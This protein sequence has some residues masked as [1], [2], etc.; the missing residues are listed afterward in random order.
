MRNLLSV[1][2]KTRLDN[3]FEAI[4]DQD[5]D[6]ISSYLG[7]LTNLTGI[8]DDGNTFMHLVCSDIAEI[9]ELDQKHP[10]LK[11][12][13]QLTKILE[14]DQASAEFLNNNKE[15]PLL[16]MLEAIHY[17][18][19]NKPY[20]DTLLSYTNTID[21]P[22]T[23]SNQTLLSQA[24][25]YDQSYI[26]P[27]LEHDASPLRPVG[28]DEFACSNFLRKFSGS[29]KDMAFLKSLLKEQALS[30]EFLNHVIKKSLFNQKLHAELE[31]LSQSDPD[32]FK[33]LLN[34][35]NKQDPKTLKSL[36]Q[37]LTKTI[38]AKLPSLC[39]ILVDQKFPP[40]R[41]LLETLSIARRSNMPKAEFYDQIYTLAA[42]TGV[43]NQE[44]AITLNEY[45]YLKLMAKHGNGPDHLYWSEG[46]QTTLLHQLCHKWR[47][48]DKET[49]LVILDIIEQ[50]NSIL[51]NQKD[52]NGNRIADVILASEDPD[53]IQAAGVLEILIGKGQE[54]ELF[55]Y[56]T[57]EELA[58][59]RFRHKKNPEMMDRIHRQD[60][61][62]SDREVIRRLIDIASS[63]GNVSFL[64]DVEGNQHFVP[65]L[66]EHERAMRLLKS[67]VPELIE[68]HAKKMTHTLYKNPNA[69]VPMKQEEVR[70]T[71]ASWREKKELSKS[72]YVGSPEEL[73]RYLEAQKKPASRTTTPQILYLEDQGHAIT[74]V[75]YPNQKQPDQPTFFFIDSFGSKGRD[76]RM[77]FA[78]R[79]FTVAYKHYPKAMVKEAFDSRQTSDFTCRI[80]SLND[81][82]YIEKNLT[83]EGLFEHINNPQHN[84]K[85]SVSEHGQHIDA[86]T[87]PRGMMRDSNNLYI[88]KKKD[89]AL[90]HRLTEYE[91]EIFNKRNESMPVFLRR[92]LAKDTARNHYLDIKLEHMQRDVVGFIL[93]LEDKIQQDL[94]KEAIG[95]SPIEQRILQSEKYGRVEDAIRAREQSVKFES[96]TRY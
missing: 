28:S 72:I 39:T 50:H 21:T 37:L 78:Q 62:D 94:D 92:V 9:I 86:V 6:Q 16:L 44:M 64:K 63:C 65:L 34:N 87:L 11:L 68:Q 83:V 81:L 41:S 23:E 51:W 54:Q 75:F 95:K 24:F 12:W 3:L 4:Q 56:Y 85:H 25:Q 19:P 80:R 33:S 70:L 26:D 46:K 22:I 40:R 45:A 76:E 29:V 71:L 96:P 47:L 20:I 90:S 60:P 30:L 35:A 36:R 27:L 42:E 57:K 18:D 69:F 5:V 79:F 8:N 59:F 91:G 73:T 58:V 61:T 74:L 10:E 49:K 67:D 13:E 84:R 31:S 43:L 93:N 55:H 14:Q 88:N 15:T 52:S 1:S 53:I 17:I 48:K 66:N 7:A 38:E 32:I 2:E 77:N 82:R 89:T